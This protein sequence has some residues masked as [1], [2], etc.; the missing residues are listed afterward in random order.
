[1]GSHEPDDTINHS[2]DLHAT[3]TQ[4]YNYLS[5]VASLVGDHSSRNLDHNTSD[6]SGQSTH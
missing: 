4:C 1:V 6:S 3:S 5:A 2:A